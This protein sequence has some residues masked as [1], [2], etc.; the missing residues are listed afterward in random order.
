M[1]LEYFDDRYRLTIF[2]FLTK[3]FSPAFTRMKICVFLSFIIVYFHYIRTNDANEN[4]FKG[5]ICMLIIV[6]IFLFPN[7]VFF[8][9]LKQ[10]F[11]SYVCLQI[12]GISG[13]PNICGCENF[14]R[15]C[16]ILDCHLNGF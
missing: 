2:A 8:E 1:S 9:C 16:L 10:Q 14:C 6:K 12:M 11:F 13:T 7:K 15:N 4:G 5:C 3:K